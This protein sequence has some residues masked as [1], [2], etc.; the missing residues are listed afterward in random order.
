[1]YMSYLYVFLG[2]LARAVLPWLL[3][4]YESKEKIDWDWTYLR[5][6][7]IAVLVIVVAIPLLITDLNSVAGWDWQTAWLAG[8]AVADVGR[9]V[10]KLALK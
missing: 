8:Y 2:I 5:G 7:L 4:M 6:Q 3:K 9:M 10:E 1:M